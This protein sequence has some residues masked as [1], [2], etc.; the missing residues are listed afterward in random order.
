MNKSW[1]IAQDNINHLEDHACSSTS[2]NESNGD[3][4]I[5][6]SID[7]A[8]TSMYTSTEKREDFNVDG[9]SSSESEMAVSQVK[10]EFGVGNIHP[11]IVLGCERK[12]VGLPYF[13]VPNSAM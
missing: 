1:R 9:R 2:G 6:D 7:N 4:N 8:S 3:R 11:M 10:Q 12:E 5:Q 13:P